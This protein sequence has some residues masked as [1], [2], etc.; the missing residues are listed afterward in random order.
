ML[1]TTLSSLPEGNIRLSDGRRLAYAEYGDPQ[2]KPVFFFH[3]TPGSRLFH[4]PDA[5]VAASAG[6]RIIA[7]DRQ[8]SGA[9]ISSLAA[10]FWIGLT[11]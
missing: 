1:E 8:D 11:T 3:G 4:H 5:S 2:G 7:I 9:Q 10:R 6:A